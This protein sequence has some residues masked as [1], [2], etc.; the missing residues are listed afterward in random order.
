ETFT[1][2]SDTKYVQLAAYL[3]EDKYLSPDGMMEIKNTIESKLLENSIEPK[4]N[5][6]IS[7]S[8]EQGVSVTRNNVSFDAIAT[9]YFGNWFLLHPDMPVSGGYVDESAAT[10]DFCVIDDLTAWRAFGSTDVCGMEL[11]INGK[12]YTVCAVNRADRGEY[13]EYYGTKPRVYILYS[14]AAMRDNRLAFTSL[15]AVLPSPVS[16]FA[17]SIFKDAVASY[18]KEVYVITDRFS[19]IELFDNIKTFSSL[20]VMEGKSFP[21][22][23]NVARIMEAKCA[24]ILAFEGTFYILAI[25]FLTVLLILIFRPVFKHIE[26]KR[27]AKKRHAVY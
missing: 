18:T 27:I 11:E 26:E 17:E 8:R 9:V 5:Y 6:L 23:E 25:L 20:G 10:T 7:G 13:A 4:G 12:I 16:D 1:G 21:Y 3:G 24:M 15:E 14:S 22:Y 2:T 19:P